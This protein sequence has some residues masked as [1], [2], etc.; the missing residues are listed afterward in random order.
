MNKTDT[1]ISGAVNVGTPATASAVNAV[2]TAP[3]TKPK[4]PKPKSMLMLNEQT[5]ALF[6]NARLAKERGEKVGWSASIFPQEIP[7][8]LG[9]NI[10]YPENHSAGIAARHQADPFLQEC[11]GALGYS[12]DLCAYAKVNLAYA[13]VL[14]GESSIE[15]PDGGRMVKPDFLLLTNNICNQLTKWYENLARQMDIPIFFIDT[16]YNPYDYVTETRVRYVR[17][18]IDQLIQDL[19]EFTGKSWNE[20]R[21]EKIMKISQNNSRLWERA[22]DLL[23]RRPSPLSGFELFNYMSA[24]VCNRGKESSTAILEQLNAEIEQHIKDGTS[25]FPV[26]EQFRISWDG[27]ACWPYLSHNLRTLKKYGINMV[28]S[29]YGKAWAIEYEDLDGMARAYCFASTN[30][31]N[32]TTMVSRRLEALK[33]FGCEGTIYH[34]NRS[35]KVMDCQMMEVQRQLSTQA[36]VPFTSFD[37]DQADYRNYS[38]AQFET[39]IQ[40]LV[41]VMRQKKEDLINE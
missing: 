33:R 22:N 9:L 38:E 24:M 14:N 7:E 3:A 11:E 26:K 17:A 29:S 35:C 18:Q 19:C 28:A 15:L 25:T 40:G 13:A 16:C 5:T 8:T 36:G 31:D 37:G 23:D 20:E 2:S 10:L 30:G 39:R 34:V 27:I 1:V 6:E 12:N 41:E 4:R 32:A 21:F